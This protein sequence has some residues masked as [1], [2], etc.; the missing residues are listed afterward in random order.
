MSKTVVLL[1]GGVDSTV[2]LAAAVKELGS[3]SVVALNLFY[4]QKSSRER[5][6]AKDVA[7]HYGVK[8]IALDI[9]K[10]LAFSDA[11]VLRNNALEP[12][13]EVYQKQTEVPFRN[14]LM[15]AT[16]A[17]LAQSLGAETVRFAIHADESAGQIYP[18]CKEDFFRAMASAI[19]TGTGGKLRL[20]LP[21]ID[22]SKKEVM[23]LG[24]DL[25]VPF[26]KTWSCYVNDD[27]PCGYCTGCIGR[28]KAFGSAGI[29]D[30]LQA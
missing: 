27:V 13:E 2:C 9:S 5:D 1:R 20:L 25:N 15:M 24:R 26:E 16:A 21:F 11:G 18:D 6:S 30:P 14:G 28:A 12:G 19:E 3:D 7:A 17:S 10:T 8:Y 4:G 29:K 23:E 22:M